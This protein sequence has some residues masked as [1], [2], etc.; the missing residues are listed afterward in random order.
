MDCRPRIATG[1]SIRT[2]ARVERFEDRRPFVRARREHSMLGRP[3]PT[4]VARMRA[5][6]WPD[7]EHYRLNRTVFEVTPEYDLACQW[8]RNQQENADDGE[9]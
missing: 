2:G 1:A 6:P 8:R 3:D 5:T 9:W 4:M 7:G